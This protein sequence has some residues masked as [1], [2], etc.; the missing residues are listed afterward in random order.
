MHFVQ[1]GSHRKADMNIETKNLKLVA[2][3]I[4][5]LGTCAASLYVIDLSVGLSGTGARKI[6]AGLQFETA[7][8]LGMLMGAL[9]LALHRRN[10][11]MKLQAKI[12]E[13][14]ALE[15]GFQER[16][17]NAHAIVTVTDPDGLIT[18][19]NDRF[20]GTFGYDRCDIVG[21][22]ASVVYQSQEKDVAFAEACNAANSGK[23]W[24]GEHK[25]TTKSGKALFMQCT[26]V[27]VHDENGRH[28]K[29]VSMRTDVTA[30][31]KADGDRILKAMLDDLQDE[32]FIFDVETL[33]VKYMNDSALHRCEWTLEQARAKSIVDTGKDFNVK[34]FRFHVAPLF[35]GEQQSVVIELPHDKG[36]VEICTKLFEGEDGRMLFLSVLR[37]ITERKKLE[38]ARM[39]TVSV[40]SHELRTPLT[41]I[42]GAL[43]LLKSGTLGPLAGEAASV[44]DI[45]DRNSDRLLT[46]VNDILDL[47]KIHAGKMKFEKARLSLTD[48]VQ[49][50]VEMN[51][52]YGDEYE[53]ALAADV[54]D[55]G[56]FVMGNAD[57]LMQVMSNLISNATKFSANGDTVTVSVKDAG[58]CWRV[59]VSDNGPGIPESVG[60]SIF[61][62]FAQ[63]E[64]ADG[65]ERKGT[66]L[67]LTITKKI[68][69]LHSGRIGY[70]SKVGQ[71]T[72]FYF[73]LPKL[74]VDEDRVGMPPV[75][76]A[77]E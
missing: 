14:Q 50:A 44:L 29:N 52:G 5:I 72:T 69:E 73:D 19:V 47:E 7:I 30:A 28:I 45:A 6:G 39:E 1:A 35:T 75:S 43:R 71:G 3:L 13:R 56:A 51:K 53:V 76:I 54:G 33:D 15:I 59:M 18:S 16:A 60:Q 49:D 27:P 58:T 24:V 8:V 31:R 38:R 70:D 66:G 36:P 63:A 48:V 2:I 55:H 42:K 62:S 10:Q 11:I 25:A 22:S 12:V 9:A 17:M 77:A 46:I 67:G 4:A 32:V 41:S 74:A 23:V 64:P 61:G 26:L 20:L 68:V 40:V 34:M 65:L 57:R 37:D 21:Q